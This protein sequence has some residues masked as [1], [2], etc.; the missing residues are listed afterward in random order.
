MLNQQIQQIPS[1]AQVRINFQK[2]DD[3]IIESKSKAS[4]R[5]M[6]DGNVSV[7]G[8]LVDGINLK[9]TFDDEPAEDMSNELKGM[10][11]NLRLT[12]DQW[13]A[14]N[15]EFHLMESKVGA[16]IQVE[17]SGDVAYG[18]LVVRGEEVE[19]YT[20]YVADVQEIEEVKIG[21]VGT[22]DKKSA[23]LERMRAQK[24]RETEKRNAAIGK[25][26]PTTAAAAEGAK[27]M[28]LN[29]G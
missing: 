28:S 5:L 15:H 17:I 14:V 9:M 25:R 24:V 2:N 8:T 29:F 6:K 19:S 13:K 23:V 11:V 3:K 4:N 1:V 21:R 26:R 12:P 16:M 22:R 18:T 7:V 27:Q 20:M 10:T